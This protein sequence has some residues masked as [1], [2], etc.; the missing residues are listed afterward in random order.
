MKPP[1]G[2]GVAAYL[3]AAFNLPGHLQVV[4]DIVLKVVRVD[5]VLAGVV[6]RVDIDELHLAGVGFLEKLENFKIVT[7]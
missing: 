1:A 7:L 3:P 2:L 6:R 4:L 5:E